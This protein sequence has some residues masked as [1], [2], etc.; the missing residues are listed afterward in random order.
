MEN[1]NSC[2]NAL[3][4]SDKEIQNLQDARKHLYD[5]RLAEM[6]RDVKGAEYQPRTELTA[7]IDELIANP[8]GEN[9]DNLDEKYRGLVSRMRNDLTGWM[10]Q[11]RNP[12]YI[13]TTFRIESDC[14]LICGRI[15]A[16]CLYMR[17]LV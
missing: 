13:Y 6:I 9:L 11:S 5:S 16:V 10:I 3:E 4:L 12:A 2:E 7:L 1:F 14:R 17:N 8:T 15:E